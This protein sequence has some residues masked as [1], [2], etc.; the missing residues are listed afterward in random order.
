MELQIAGVTKESVVDGPGLRFVI[1]TQGCPHRCPG[2]HNPETHDPRGG[3]RVDV[4]SVLQMIEQTKLLRGITFSGGEPFMQ[5]KP[6]YSIAREVKSNR[7]K[8]DV[9]TYTGYKFEELL[10]MARSSED[11]QLLLTATDILIDGPFQRGE[12]NLSLA[13][14]GSNNQRLINV[15][16]SLAEK[17]IVLWD[18]A[19]I[20]RFYM[21]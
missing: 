11:V 2:C 5:P 17:E 3:K 4:T 20:K 16:R 7:L 8:L 19:T 18:E 13:F 15:S 21:Q 12:R 14:R 10:T 1:F 9:V 6:L